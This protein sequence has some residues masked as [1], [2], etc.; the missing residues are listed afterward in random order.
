ML[1]ASILV[2]QGSADTAISSKS[3]SRY[4]GF[5]KIL[6]KISRN[7]KIDL[8]YLIHFADSFTRP[9][10]HHKRLFI[11]SKAKS[12][13]HISRSIDFKFFGILILR[14]SENLKNRSARNTLC[15]TTQHYT[16]LTKQTEATHGRSSCVATVVLTVNSKYCP[17]Q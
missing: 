16:N 10:T 3:V 2:S 17:K 7:Q 14:K 1:V 15:G 9:S 6:D 5:S 4:R 13:A 12:M 8:A 11:N